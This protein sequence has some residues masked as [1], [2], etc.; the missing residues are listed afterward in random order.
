[1]NSKKLKGKIVEKGITQVKLAEKV[2]ISVQSLNAKLNDRSSFTIEE[3]DKITAI[4]HLDNPG[5]I[6]FANLG[7]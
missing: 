3:A 4:L 2:G 5:D 6:F 7:Q 1:M